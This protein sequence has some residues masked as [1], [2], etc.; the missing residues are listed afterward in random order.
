[1]IF[2]IKIMITSIISVIKIKVISADSDVD[3]S[4]S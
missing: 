2:N 4:L 1:M 3:S